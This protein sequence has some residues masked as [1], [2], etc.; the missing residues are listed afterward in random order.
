MTTASKKPTIPQ[1]DKPVKKP[2]LPFPFWVPIVVICVLGLVGFGIY[3]QFFSK[4]EGVSKIFDLKGK[5]STLT[6]TPSLGGGLPQFAQFKEEEVTITPSIPDYSLSASELEN[7]QAIEEATGQVLNQDQLTALSS[8]GFFTTKAENLLADGETQIDFRHGSV[9]EY[10]MLYETIYGDSS[11]E[12]RKPENAVFITSDFLL[13][14]FH[15]FLDRTFQSIEETQ[16]QPKLLT[17]SNQLYQASLSEYKKA[18]HPQVKASF[19]RLSGFFLV[20]KV[21]LE[22]SLPIKTGDQFSYT[23]PDQVETQ[24]KADQEADK[25]EKILANLEGYK[26]QIPQDLYQK[27][28]EEIELINQAEGARLSPI[29]GEFKPDQPEDYTQYKPRSHYYKNSVLRSY[30]K[31]MIW[32]GR[33][34][35]IVKSDELILDAVNQTILLTGNQEA[36]KLWE[37]IYLPTVFFV[38]KSD[39]LTVYDYQ[40]ATNQ[41][42]GKSPKFEKIV[43]EQKFAKFKEKVKEMASPQIQSSIVFIMPDKPT[44]EEVLEDTKSFRFMGQRFIPD[45][46]IFSY[47]TQGDEAP[48]KET[49]QKL[50]PIPTALM[51]MSIFGSNL[52]QTH[53][54]SWILEKAPDSDKVIP[55]KQTEL[56]EMFD[57]LTPEDWTQNLYWSWLHT[58]KSLFVEFSKGYPMFMQNTAWNTKDLNTALGS[59]TELRH[60]TLLYAKQSYAELGGGAPDEEVPPVPKGYVEPNLVFLNRI[61][62][63]AEMT[64]D[65]LETNQVLPE[66]QKVKLEGLTEYFKFYREIAKKELQNQPISDDEFE[67]LRVSPAQINHALTPPSYSLSLMRARDARAGLIADVH[68]ATT[69]KVQ[70]ILY[71]A[72]GIPNLIFVAVK[73]IN[74]TRLTRGLTYSYFEF[75]RPF[76]ERLSDVDWQEIIYEGQGDFSPNI[77]EWVKQLEK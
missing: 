6:T 33:N 1:T 75:T 76:G 45:S 5:L 21:I 39:D 59:W 72:T 37:N 71:E 61:I 27:V 18:N 30:W 17:L 22:T 35:F 40:E 28:K 54:D 62:G 51:P 34:G 24:E 44:K 73:D 64:K 69:M 57:K 49:G 36:L 42:Y 20:P 14:S 48:D 10:I 15:V 52:A 12:D 43:E 47:L 32:Y 7:K 60:D 13:H 25:E 56:E 23:P 11:P 68:T 53:L 41:V 77:P 2:K 38:G 4:E 9:D 66:E 74:G 31:A 70:E 63:L 16:F 8:P 3:F 26:S 50:P 55:K 65:G 46:Y 58:L 19:A 29:F 67:K